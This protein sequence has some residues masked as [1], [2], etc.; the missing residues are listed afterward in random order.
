[1]TDWYEF[2]LFLE[3]AIGFSMDAMHVIAG[4]L[5][6]LLAAALLRSSVAR[7]PPWLAALAIELLNEFSDLA[8]ERWPKPG[9]QLGEG[10]KDVLLTMALPT[11]LLIVA[12]TRPR[13]LA[14]PSGS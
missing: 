5:V 6:Q 11:V 4:V 13:L 2:K 14:P 7:W 10:A 9:M 3:H 1:M 8:V 12:R